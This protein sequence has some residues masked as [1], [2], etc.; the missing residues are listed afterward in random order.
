MLQRAYRIR[1]V[2]LATLFSATCGAQNLDTK[3]VK[4]I[5]SK[6]GFTGLLRGRITFTLLGNM[7]CN[8][9]MLRVYYYTWEES[10]PPG[11]AIHFSQR[12]IFIE[13]RN[14]LGHYVIADRP[15]LIKGDFL[16]FPYSKDDGDS[17]QCDQEGL[18]ESVHLNG[19]NLALER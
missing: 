3:S 4:D 13:N 7:K 14:Y 19:D 15:T 10:N 17:I 11:R 18:P 8:S 1:L 6:Q 5:L 12:L 9:T 16:R 2:L